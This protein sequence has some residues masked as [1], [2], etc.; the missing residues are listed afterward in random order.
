MLRRGLTRPWRW[1]LISAGARCAQARSV[2]RIRPGA[3]APGALARDQWGRSAAAPVRSLPSGAISGPRSACARPLVPSGAISATG[4]AA[5][6]VRPGPQ[7]TQTRW[8]G[9]AALRSGRRLE[10]SGHIAIH[11]FRIAGRA[12]EL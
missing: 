4:S 3:G 7:S 8:G 9:P 12:L 11:L 6:P 10:L 2:G 1:G 5:A